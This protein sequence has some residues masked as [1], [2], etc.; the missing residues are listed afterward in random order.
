MTS[1]MRLIVGLL[2]FSFCATGA[3]YVCRAGELL[4]Q[5]G[6]WLQA[7]GQDYQGE[8]ADP[9]DSLA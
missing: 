1:Y 7:E 4:P 6:E 5:A 8:I 9:S 2:G 3:D